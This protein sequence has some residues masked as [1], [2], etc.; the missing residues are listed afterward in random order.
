MNTNNL[1]FSRHIPS[2]H[3]GFTLVEI[4]VGLV[5]GMLA[6]VVIM[7]VFSVFEAQ[8]RTTTGTADAQVN[9]S[10]ALFTITRDL[11]VAGYPLMPSSDTPLKCTTLNSGT[12][13]TNITDISPVA[14]LDG[15]A[16]GSDSITVRYGSSP[17][18]GATTLITA[19]PVGN[20]VTVENNLGCAAND[21]TVITNGPACALSSASAVTG[22]VAPYTITMQDTTGAVV[23]AKLACLGSWNNLT[24]AVNQGNLERN[25]TPIITGIVNLQVQY[26]I[27][28]TRDSNQVTDWVDATAASGWAI[29]TIDNRNRIKAIRIAVVSRNEKMEATAVTTNLNSWVSLTAASAPAIDLSANANWQ[30]YRYRVFETIVPLRNV[31]W[32]RDILI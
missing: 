19:L 6:T 31:I 16:G 8:K 23:G 18:G 14:I 11:Q 32:S 5:I 4:M 28:A 13:A 22:T 15:G 26:G 3:A 29:P 27:S 25:G 10:I 24:Y 1:Q 2:K 17:F 7:Q 30:R 12:G 9:G 21:I 20:D